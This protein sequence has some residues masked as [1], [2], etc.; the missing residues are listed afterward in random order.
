[1]VDA[2]GVMLYK[3][4]AG[5]GISEK[6]MTLF[7]FKHTHNIDLL[8]HAR[9]RPVRSS[10]LTGTGMTTLSS[11]TAPRVPRPPSAEGAT[12]A[13]AGEL[14]P[15]VTSRAGL[16]G[17]DE[18]RPRSSEMQ[19]AGSIEDDEDQAKSTMQESCFGW[20]H[21]KWLA[22][23]DILNAE[24]VRRRSFGATVCGHPKV[25]AGQV[26]TPVS[27]GC[28]LARVSLNPGVL[29]VMQ[30]LA[31]PE[32]RTDMFVWQ[33]RAGR[34]REGKTYQECWRELLHDRDGPVLALGLYRLLREEEVANEDDPPVGFV[35]TNPRPEVPLREDDLIYAVGP[36]GW[37][38]RMHQEGQ[39]LNSAGERE[40]YTRLSFTADDAHDES[41]VTD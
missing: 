21:E 39:L 9:A 32:A 31:M 7:E 41:F 24:G 10:L 8:S 26:F 25:I 38:R 5:L 13:A 17:R 36:T 15:Q 29:Q 30:A 6:A 23:S 40:T 1:M 33:I 19:L 4:L 34:T 2:E 14:Q 37:G 28:M 22:W 12:M 16:L 3:M 20:L 27:I 18:G 35:M 11:V